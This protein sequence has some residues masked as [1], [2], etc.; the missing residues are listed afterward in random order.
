MAPCILSSCSVP[1]LGRIA[2]RRRLAVDK[3]VAGMV[4]RRRLAAS[5]GRLA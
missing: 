2:S 4:G 3:P 1:A 5:E